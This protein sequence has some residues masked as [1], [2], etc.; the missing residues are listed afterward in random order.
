MKRVMMIY[1]GRS[2]EHEVSLRSASFVWKS[3]RTAEFQVI[4]VGIAPDG[5]WYLQDSLNSIPE[6]LPLIQDNSR[7]LSLIPG[8]CWLKSDGS[9]LSIDLVF[10]VLHGTFGE[11]GT[12]QGLLEMMDIPYVGAHVL[13]SSMAMDKI[14]A[15]ILWESKD[16]PIVPFAWVE[17]WEW[18]SDSYNRKTHIEKWIKK[19]G[20]PLFIKPS[21][22]GSSV[23]VVKAETSADIE[24]AVKEALQYDTRILIEK[25]VDARE[26][27]LSVIGNH[28]VTVFPPG[29][30][31][32]T[33]SFYDYDAKYIDP[34]GAA[35]LIPADLSEEEQNQA[36]NI[37]EKA[38]RTLCL[39]GLSR[40]DLFLDKKDGN[41]YINEINTL[42]GFTSISM[43]PVLCRESGTGPAALMS[44]LIELAEQSYKE[45]REL[46]FS[47]S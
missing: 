23:G 17:S 2:G 19:L 21:N 6:I 22:A 25:A 47:R 7:L 15:K 32:P 31:A 46:H 38:Y 4:P 16:L 14:I 11:D 34:D 45:R 5:L 40:V 37:A 1:G 3:L 43:F 44:K 30:I 42:P 28:D 20:L 27:E 13:S 9:E 8:K 41:F 36:M 26:I 18:N 39:Q 10:P 29:E 35:L 33:H 12:L 24:P